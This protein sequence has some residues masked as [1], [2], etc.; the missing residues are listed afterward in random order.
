MILKPAIAPSFFKAGFFGATGT[1]K[2]FTAAKV[3][4]QFISEYAKGSQL[5][6]FDTEPSAGFVAPMVKKITGKELLVCSSRSFSDLTEFTDDCIKNNYVALVDSITHPW[7]Q[8]CADFLEAKKSRVQGAGGRKET[9]RLSL[10]DWGPIKDIWNT[11]SEKFVFSPIHF[12]ICGREGDAWDT[13]TDEEGKEEMQKVGVKMK[14]ETE[15]GHEPSL[16]VNMRLEY[17]KHLA[18]VSK[19]RFDFLTGALSG[20]NPDIEFFR[21]HI[22]ALNLGGEHIVKS[23]GKKIFNAGTGPN[24]ETIKAQRAAILEN[25]K[26]DILL[27][28]PSTSAEEKKAKVEVLRAAFGTSAWTE[29]EEDEKKF[30]YEELQL[31]RVKLQQIIKERQDVKNS[32]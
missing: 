29:L 32:R 16:L 17:D 6:M 4:S 5:A 20:N 23:E 26:D 13:V 31:G 2:T 28:Y 24:W 21:P 14:T 3:M 9:T 8:L 11:F 15:F 27:V 1:G 19:D 12:C 10:K 7:R 25:I 18:F 30:P 22:S